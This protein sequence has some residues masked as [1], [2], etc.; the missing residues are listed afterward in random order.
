MH[1]VMAVAPVSL[2][3]TPLLAGQ[4]VQDVARSVSLLKVPEP[5]F[6]QVVPLIFSPGPQ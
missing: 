5:Q 3:S 1:A 2:L 4:P 6:T